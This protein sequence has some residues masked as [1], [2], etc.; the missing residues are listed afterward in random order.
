MGVYVCPGELSLC[1]VELYVC[2]EDS[3][4]VHVEKM[5]CVCVQDCMSV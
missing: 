2:V 3:V 5:L 1:V 4:C